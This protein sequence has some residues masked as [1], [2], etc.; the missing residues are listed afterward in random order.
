[1]SHVVSW[2]MF[3][4]AVALQLTAVERTE[5]ETMT[6]S[7]R[8]PAGLVRRARLILALAEGAPYEKITAHLG[9]APSSISRWKRRFHHARVGGL[10]D[11]LRSG[12]PDRLSPA[13]EA[14]I[15]AVTQQPPPRP[16]THWSVRRLAHRLG[17][18]PATVHR[19]WQRAGLKP[20]RLEHYTASSD[21]DFERKAADILGLYLHPP[22]HAAVFCVDE[23]TAIQALDRRDPVLPLSPGRAERHG[24]EYFRHGA[25]SL[26]AALDVS[27]GRVE[28]RTAARHTSPEFLVFLEHLVNRQPK[29]RALHLIVDNFSAHKTKAVQAWLAAHPRVALHYT[30]TYSSWLNQVELWFAKIERD[31]IARGIFTSVP[32]LRRKLMQYIRAHNKT[33]RP[34]AWAYSNPRHRIRTTGIPETVH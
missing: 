12:R 11:A 7:T 6:R 10:H 18:S 34:F 29:R 30:P 9:F 21:P 32:D 4:T 2:G 20:H 28:A 14:K 31:C 33:C 24:F 15:I 25:L 17:V 23:K 3:T 19:V 26:Y 22:A 16:Y 27:T 5:L 8:L 13:L 1:M